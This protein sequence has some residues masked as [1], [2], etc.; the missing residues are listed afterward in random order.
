MSEDFEFAGYFPEDESEEFSDAESALAEAIRNANE[1]V[2][3]RQHAK[4]D[5][6]QT[7]GAIHTLLDVPG[8]Y[9]ALENDK[10]LRRAVKVKARQFIRNDPRFV[11]W[12]KSGKLAKSVRVRF[13]GIHQFEWTLVIGDTQEDIVDGLARAG[14]RMPDFSWDPALISTIS[15][16]QS[17]TDI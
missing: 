2:W 16:H 14:V 5:R 10:S 1:T 7:K 13:K 3:D 6:Q 12:M 15:L 17:S 4:R 9:V 8:S 11:E